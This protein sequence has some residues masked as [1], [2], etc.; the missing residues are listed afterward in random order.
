MLHQA[1]SYSHSSQLA[2]PSTPLLS[3]MSTQ[4]QN[5]PPATASALRGNREI[6]KLWGPFNSSSNDSVWFLSQPSPCCGQ[7]KPVSKGLPERTDLAET[8]EFSSAL[9]SF[10]LKLAPCPPWGESRGPGLTNLLQVNRWRGR[11]GETLLDTLHREQKGVTSQHQQPRLGFATFPQAAAKT[12]GFAH[13]SGAT[14]IRSG[15]SQNTS[16]DI[17]LQVHALLYAGA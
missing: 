4:T 15:C 10:V 5:S 7:V 8:S 3:L 6:Q 11:P 1:H 9:Q 12:P 17:T 13:G 14:G 16:T 2:T